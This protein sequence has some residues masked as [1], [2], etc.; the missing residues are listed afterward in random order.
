MKPVAY[1]QVARTYRIAF[2]RCEEMRPLPSGKF[3]MPI[4]PGIVCAIFSIE[5][6]IKGLLAKQG[7]TTRVHDLRK[8]FDR[9]EASQKDEIVLACGVPEPNFSQQLDEIR[10]GYVRWRYFFEHEGLNL[11][12][13]FVRKLSDAA[14]SVADKAIAA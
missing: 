4:M 11:D 10:D 1:L 9:L 7:I 2:R 12:L 3:E 14:I 8:L 6:A 13:S 5:L